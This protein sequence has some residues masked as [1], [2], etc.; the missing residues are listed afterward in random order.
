MRL[1][2]ACESVQCFLFGAESSEYGPRYVTLEPSTFEEYIGKGLII[3]SKRYLFKT[4]LY[5]VYSKNVSSSARTATFDSS[6]AIKGNTILL[7]ID[8]D[9]GPTGL[10]DFDVELIKENTMMCYDS[11][12]LYLTLYNLTKEPQ[13]MVST[14]E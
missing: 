6:G 14:D 12:G 9:R 4:R 13:E 1:C 2:H 8:G 7:G 10:S 5:A 3:F 11:K